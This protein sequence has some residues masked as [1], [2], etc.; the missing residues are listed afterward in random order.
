[1]N[2]PDPSLYDW[3]E[4]ENMENARD[5]A[6]HTACSNLAAHIGVIV[7][8]GIAPDDVRAYVERVVTECEK[9]YGK[10]SADKS[11]GE[12]FEAMFAPEAPNLQVLP[13]GKGKGEPS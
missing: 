8:L 13:G 9:M 12:N 7:G 1:M 3:F 6:L 10:I 11:L 2:L 4:R 5:V